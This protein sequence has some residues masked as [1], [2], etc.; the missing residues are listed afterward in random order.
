MRKRCRSRRMGLVG[1]D[2]GVFGV[3]FAF[4]AVALGGTVDGPAGEDK[5]EHGLVDQCL[6]QF[7]V[8]S[9]MTS[10]SS[11]ILPPWLA[12]GADG[13]ET[14][15]GALGHAFSLRGA[16]FLIRVMHAWS[17][18]ARVRS[19][20]TRLL[21]VGVANECAVLCRMTICQPLGLGQSAGS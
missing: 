3:G 1:D 9:P 19:G 6:L 2:G 16:W 17:D 4:A 14:G 18:G 5:A 12:G 13:V 21:A 10:R 7:A 8:L 11:E 15:A 20:R